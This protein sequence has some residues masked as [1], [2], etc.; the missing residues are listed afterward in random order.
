MGSGT[1]IRALL[2]SACLVLVCGSVACQPLYGGK[3]EKLRNPDRK[4]KPPE[5]AEKPIEIKYVDDCVANFRDDP[6]LVRPDSS[7]SNALVGDGDS[8]IAQVPKAKDAAGAAELIKQSIDK[9]RSALI[10]DPYNAE[11]TLRLA[12]AYDM[13]YRKGCAIALLK[14]I[15]ALES[16]PRFKNAAKRVADAVADD[17]QLFKGYRKD[18]VSAVGR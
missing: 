8:T 9:Y 17:G 5:E 14:R 4:K 1:S 11:A 7:R 2:L 3:P 6:K 16:N 13:V 18:A 10:K 12:V 15:A